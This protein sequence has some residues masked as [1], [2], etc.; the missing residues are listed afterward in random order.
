MPVL[1]PIK[2]ADLSFPAFVPAVDVFDQGAERR[3]SGSRAHHQ[4][5]AGLVARDAERAAV[6]AGD[7][8]GIAGAR[9]AEKFEALPG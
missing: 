6:G 8:N 5:V 2:Q 3:D 7:L 9:V 1:A 4:Q